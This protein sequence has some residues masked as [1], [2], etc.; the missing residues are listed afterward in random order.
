[1]IVL[2]RS[3]NRAMKTSVYNFHKL[4]KTVKSTQIFLDLAKYFNILKILSLNLFLRHLTQSPFIT[5]NQLLNCHL[6]ICNFLTRA[7]G[8]ITRAMTFLLSC[9]SSPAIKSYKLQGLT[10]QGKTY[11]M[12]WKK[13]QNLQVLARHIKQHHSA[14]EI[15]IL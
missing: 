5:F 15:T 12:T 4:S 8:Y 2:C 11:Y 1:M 3:K 14:R 13:E 7:R 6:K 10:V 9:R